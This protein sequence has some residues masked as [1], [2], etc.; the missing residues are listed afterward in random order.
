MKNILVVEQHEWITI[1]DE[2]QTKKKNW[3]IHKKKKSHTNTLWE[4]N[5]CY[6]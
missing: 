6:S 5:R 3:K 2:I 1:N 4:K